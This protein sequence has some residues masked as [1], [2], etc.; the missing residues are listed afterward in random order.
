MDTSEM[1]CNLKDS[2]RGFLQCSSP[3]HPTYSNTPFSN[4]FVPR[5]SRCQMKRVSRFHLAFRRLLVFDLSIPGSSAP[6]PF[7]PFP[8]GSAPARPTSTLSRYQAVLELWCMSFTQ[9]PPRYRH[10][11]IMAHPGIGTAICATH[12]PLK[13]WHTFATIPKPTRNEFRSG[14]HPMSG[15]VLDSSL[16]P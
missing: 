14:P 7:P 16:R 6:S 15:R 4:T 5:H 11:R 1:V 9:L 12:S 3:V 10:D 2:P 8:H 13:E